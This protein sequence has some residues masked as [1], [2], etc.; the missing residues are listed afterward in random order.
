MKKSFELLVG[1]I[2]LFLLFAIPASADPTI[3]VLPQ[4]TLTSTGQA[5]IVS[6][7]A[8]NITDLGY[9]QLDVGF[10]PTL[11]EA[12]FVAEDVFLPDWAANLDPPGSTFWD[13]G[14]IDNTGGTISFI[15]EG[16]LGSY[17]P[18]SMATGS[19]SL[20]LIQFKALS[21]GTGYVNVLNG[22][23][24][25]SNLDPITVSLASGEVD[26]ARS[27][28]VPEP[29]SLLLLACGLMPLAFVPWRR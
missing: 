14:T 12:V 25:D 20:L 19:G 27:S 5:F 1:S 24:L 10:D 6:I 4:V 22:Q 15:Y 18:G 11:M 2:S 7:S 3:A 9:F 29:S 21:P 16:I 17:P 28:A 13:P 26:I 8:L 23:F